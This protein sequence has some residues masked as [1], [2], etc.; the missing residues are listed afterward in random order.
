MEY[1]KTHL[2]N[3]HGDRQVVETRNADEEIRWLNESTNS[4]YHLDVD[5]YL[6]NGYSKAED[7]FTRIERGYGSISQ[8]EI[9]NNEWL[10]I[11]EAKE[12]AMKAISK[13][14][15]GH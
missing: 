1:R 12:E 7:A 5:W 6:A 2:I 10:T 8:E 14:Y 15:E 3:E 11:D 4:T 13:E 9:C